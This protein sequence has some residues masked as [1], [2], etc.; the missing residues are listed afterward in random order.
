M[1]LKN[2]VSVAPHKFVACYGDKLRNFE[3]RGNRRSHR[4]MSCA[5]HMFLLAVP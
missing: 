4:L 2:G 3:A 5:P 1:L